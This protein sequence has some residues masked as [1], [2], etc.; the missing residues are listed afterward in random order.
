MRMY[1]RYKSWGTWAIHNTDIS[2][3]GDQCSCDNC[4]IDRALDRYPCGYDSALI[5]EIMWGAI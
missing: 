4:M 3:I 2:M 1:D 5:L